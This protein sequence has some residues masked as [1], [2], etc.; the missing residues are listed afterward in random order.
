MTLKWEQI[1]LWGDTPLKLCE[2]QLHICY[3][4]GSIISVKIGQ[5]GGNADTFM[6]KFF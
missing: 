3:R 4:I 1:K 2:E 6:L 5:L